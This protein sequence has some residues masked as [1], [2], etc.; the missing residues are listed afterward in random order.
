MVVVTWSEKSPDYAR[1][2]LMAQLVGNGLDEQARQ[3]FNA[4]LDAVSLISSEGR[5][6]PTLILDHAE[7][8]SSPA[9]F[10]NPLSP[11]S[12]DESIK[13]EYLFRLSQIGEI[14]STDPLVS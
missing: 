5:F 13:L 11:F 2:L 8:L 7:C 10:A 4:G 3:L 12:I 9:F 6:S 1:S 14:S